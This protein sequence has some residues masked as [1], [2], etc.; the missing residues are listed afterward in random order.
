MALL[1]RW[2]PGHLRTGGHLRHA[3]LLL[4]VVAV[5]TALNL[6]SVAHALLTSQVELA[7]AISA[8]W[9]LAYGPVLWLLWWARLFEP[10]WQADASS[11]R[12]FGGTGLGLANAQRLSVL[13][14]GTLSVESEAGRGTAFTMSLPLRQAE[15]P[16]APVPSGQAVSLTG[17][18]VLVAEDNRINQ[19]IIRQLL[20]GLGVVVEIASDGREAIAQ[21]GADFDVILMDMQMPEVDG[22]AAIRAAGVS[23]PIVALTANVL[24]DDRKKCREAG[25]NGFLG[26]PLDET[27]LLEALRRLNRRRSA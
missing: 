8:Q 17:L 27:D 4:C 7:A 13:M 12:R 2:L 6:V 21:A 18:R 19:L 9:V 15:A 20:E 3:R 1:D 22:L 24:P 14:G 11:S 26:K 16:V 25:M 10:L 5:L 23:V